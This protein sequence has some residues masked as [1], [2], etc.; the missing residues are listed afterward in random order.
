MLQLF[1]YNWQVR[2][3]WFAWCEQLSDEEWAQIR[4]GGLG[5]FPATLFHIVDTEICWIKRMKKEPDEIP[6]AGD[7]KFLEQIRFL[8]KKYRPEIAEF[9]FD[10]N[11]QK[12]SATTPL[13]PYTFGEIMRHIIVHEIHHIGQ[14]SVWSQQMGMKAVS[15]NVIGRQLSFPRSV[16]EKGEVTSEPGE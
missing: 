14:L 12:E 16:Q 4:T 8:S 2:D 13:I 10:W 1:L 9:V 5:T 7:Y 11:E 6:D 3:E 15:A